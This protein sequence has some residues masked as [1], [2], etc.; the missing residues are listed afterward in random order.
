LAE[1]PSMP[2]DLDAPDKRARVR[3][4]A[5][6]TTVALIV[7]A[8]MV[9]VSAPCSSAEPAVLFSAPRAWH[10]VPQRVR[11][12]ATAPRFT[13]RAQM[14]LRGLKPMA[15]EKGLVKEVEEPDPLG[16]GWLTSWGKLLGYEFPDEARTTNLANDEHYEPFA[17]ERRF[18]PAHRA[19]GRA[20]TSAEQWRQDEL[21][22]KSLLDGDDWRTSWGQHFGFEFPK[23]LPQGDDELMHKLSP[24][25]PTALNY[26]PSLSPLIAS[27]FAPT[28]TRVCVRATNID[29]TLSL[30]Q[31]RPTRMLTAGFPGGSSSQPTRTCAPPASCAPSSTKP[32]GMAPARSTRTRCCSLCAVSTLS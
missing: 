7:G 24:G 12:A 4:L 32:T 1:L 3:A 2:S 13:L 25:A 8:V 11:V 18:G 30:P 17:A 15:R 6:A 27:F 22:H 5:L 23:E 28:T 20:V 26:L 19:V 14:T 31:A 29:P 9:L 16:D 10:A 21:M